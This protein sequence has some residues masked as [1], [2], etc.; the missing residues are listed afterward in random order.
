MLVKTFGSA[1][2]GITAN[3]ITVEAIATAVYTFRK[4]SGN[5]YAIR[6]PNITS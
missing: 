5:A 3:I 1:I 2:Q 6:T 4:I